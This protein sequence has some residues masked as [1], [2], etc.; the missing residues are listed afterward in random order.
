[1]RYEPPKPRGEASKWELIE[2]AHA[3]IHEGFMRLHAQEREVDAIIVELSRRRETANCSHTNLARGGDNLWCRDC[4]FFPIPFPDEEK[5]DNGQKV[6][7]GG[8]AHF[9]DI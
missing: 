9:V 1:M 2:E 5:A 3:I 6:E 8:V 7:V 4:G